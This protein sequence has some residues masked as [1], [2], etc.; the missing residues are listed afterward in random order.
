MKKRL[1]ILVCMVIMA[2]AFA[3]PAQAAEATSV[4]IN[5]NPL[6]VQPVLENGR[7]LVPMRAIFEAL[8]ASVEWDEQTK[9]VTAKKFTTE[10]KI[11]I[12]GKAL[13]NSEEVTLDVPAKIV[14][15][16]TLVPL[17]FVGEAL[18]AQVEWDS[19]T[20]TISIT[21]PPP[22]E[23]YLNALPFDASKL[24]DVDREAQF[25]ITGKNAG[26]YVLKIKD[27]KITW[28]KGESKN[29]AIV[30]TTPEEIWLSVAS[31]KL[32]PTQAYSRGLF[33][34]EG[35]LAF[36]IEIIDAFITPKKAPAEQPAP[37]SAPATPAPTTTAPTTSAPATPT[38]ETPFEKYLNSLPLDASKIQGVDKVAQF[39]ITGEHEGKYVLVI[40]DGKITWSKGT[41]EN[42]AITVTTTEQVWLDVSSRK[43]DPATAFRDQKFT[44]DGDVAFFTQII[45]AFVVKKS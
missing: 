14:D 37:A 43:L 39:I 5:G 3:M 22:F 28:E 9:T 45:G 4:K 32:D 19:N 10:I 24:K 35:S 33:K 26:S 6:N 38:A 27:Q 25:N 31:R 7:T 34:A 13:K 1:H 41:A 12:G 8:G 16:K 29:P 11:S 23:Q 30:V 15:G 44:A 40:K 21:T 2:L 42:P 20:K 18:G 36:F 17:R